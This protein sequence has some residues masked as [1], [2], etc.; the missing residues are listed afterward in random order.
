MVTYTADATEA[1]FG[2]FQRKVE[3]PA[4]KELDRLVRASFQ[5]FALHL[6]Q[7]WADSLSTDFQ[8]CRKLHW[9]MTQM[10]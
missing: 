7:R 10:T 1:A 2:G 4:D 3:C 5:Q 8:F 6:N 9:V